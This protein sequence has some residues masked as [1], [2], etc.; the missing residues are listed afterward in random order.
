MLGEINN[1]PKRLKKTRAIMLAVLF[2]VTVTA[3]AV[4]AAGIAT[5]RNITTESNVVDANVLSTKST[6]FLYIGDTSDNT[7]KRF[8][9]TSGN[10]SNT[11]VS[12]GSGGLL[13]PSGILFEINGQLLVDNQNFGGTTPGDIL[14][15][16]GKTGVFE[17][18]LVNS[19][20]Q[21]PPFSPQGIVL[22][23]FKL[24]VADI[25]DVGRPG[26]VSS[27]NEHNGKFLENLTQNA[28]PDT[29]YHPRGIVFGPDGNLYVS[30]RDLPTPLG[31][32]VLRFNPN[33]SFKDVFI[34]DNGGVGNLNRP[35]GL[36][37]S[38]D[39]NLY[40][41]AS[42]QMQVI[43]IRFGFTQQTECF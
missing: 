13:G 28:I 37:F 39:G 14:R 38:P 20:D 42:G 7:V 10:F 26:N 27:Y 43:R 34:A 32:Y 25:G 6:D 36:V 41:T 24:Y 40:I 8:N 5:E 35:E 2:L 21:Y 15:Y 33:G 18:T 16:N 11:F 3:G 19:T 17:T 31:G 22:K 1:E 23:D 12:P 4:S 30:V 29:N 9:E